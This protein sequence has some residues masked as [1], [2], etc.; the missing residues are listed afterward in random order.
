MGGLWRQYDFTKLAS[1]EA[2]ER[3]PALVLQFYNE[4]RRQ[5]W[6]AQ[7]NAA[8]LAIAGLEA[9][10]DVSVITQN[11]DN[12]HER[13]GSSRVIHLHGELDKARSTRHPELIYPLQG[14][15]IR[16][17]DTCAKGAQLRPHVVWFGEP[18]TEMNH[19]AQ[20]CGTADHLLV[21]GTSLQVYPAA[22][23]VQFVPNH[24]QI[25]VVD[26]S[27]ELQVADARVFR[28]TAVIGVPKWIARLNQ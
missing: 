5:A 6:E 4:R 17:G 3:D 10:F 26:P 19:A 18:V 14:K 16:L 25:S 8:H 22:S 23:L 13:A 20:I 11:V 27:T 7:P 15:A 1:P 24:C 2:W 28:E 12:L 9:R 21:V